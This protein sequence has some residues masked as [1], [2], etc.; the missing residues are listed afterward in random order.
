MRYEVY[1]NQMLE[2]SPNSVPAKVNYA[3]CLHTQGRDI[4]TAFELYSKALMVDSQNPTILRC[5]ALLTIVSS[6]DLFHSKAWT[7]IDRA[8]ALDPK[9]QAF[10][11][12]RKYFFH[13]SLIQARKLDFNLLNVAL[14]E[15]LV[16]KRHDQAHSI[17]ARTKRVSKDHRILKVMFPMVISSTLRSAP[18]L[19]QKFGLEGDFLFAVQARRFAKRLRFSRMPSIR[20]SS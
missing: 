1:G 4:E 7:L 5:L 14:V 3:L 13:W 18:I 9:G 19:L 20:G 11:M 15:L 10:V 8:H 12:A 17:F 16:Y 2:Q 6:G